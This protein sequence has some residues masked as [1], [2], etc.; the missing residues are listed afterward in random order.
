MPRLPEYVPREGVPMSSGIGRGTVP[1]PVVGSPTADPQAQ[2]AG[3][4]AVGAVASALTESGT[5]LMQAEEFRSR[6]QQAQDVLDSRTRVQTKFRQPM[7]ARIDELRQG[8]YREFP[9]AVMREGNRLIQEV[10]AEL[11]PGARRYFEEDANQLLSVMQQQA[12]GER[13]RR[14]DQDTAFAMQ[15]EVQDFQTTLLRTQDPFERMVAKGQLEQTM[16]RFVS[17]GLVDGAKAADVL[18]KTMDTA[19]VQDVQIAIQA[20]PQGMRDQLLAQTRGEPTSPNLPTAPVEQLAALT[21][22]A[23]RVYAQA[24]N[25][26]ENQEQAVQRRVTKLQKDSAID[27]RAQLSEL[28]PIQENVPQYDKLLTEVNTRARKGELTEGDQRELLGEVRQLKNAALNPPQRDDSTIE[29]KLVIKL[30]AAQN[31]ADLAQVRQEIV[32]SAQS[33]KPETVQGF[34]G[35]VRERSR[36]DH[37]SN[38]PG[39]REGFRTLMG[40]DVAE[41]SLVPQLRGLRAEA[42]QVRLRTALDIYR[43]QVQALAEGDAQRAG[44]S[45]QANAQAPDLALR[46]RRQYVDVPGQEAKKAALPPVLQNVPTEAEAIKVLSGLP[47]TPAE[48]LRLLER[49]KQAQ[50]AEQ[51]PQAPGGA[52]P[53]ATPSGPRM[54]PPPGTALPGG[55]RQRTREGGS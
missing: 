22:E 23:T 24:L 28:A 1:V 5:A 25:F 27:L 43:T 44:N 20:N 17:T 32:A 18:Q 26:R 30:D 3:I 54:T 21:Q 16:Q 52:T 10:G 50:P 38:L 47:G 35:R 39:V 33:L 46:I 11:S 14:R 37:W 29:R 49:W 8:D 55:N 4:R 12:I 6:R 7:Q 9:E 40:A 42:E 41:G 34:L 48:R 13:T 15:R 2:T 45:E 19:A 53:S 36:S 31:P 51:A